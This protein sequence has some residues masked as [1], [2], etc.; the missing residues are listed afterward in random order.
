MVGKW[1]CKNPLT[2]DER[3]KIK[4]GLDLGM[5]YREIGEH[6]GRNKS[7]VLRESKRMGIVNK[8]EPQKAQEDFEMK[9]RIKQKRR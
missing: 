9:Q 1:S 8:Y 5:S 4:E 2:I 7:V 3:Y 6:V